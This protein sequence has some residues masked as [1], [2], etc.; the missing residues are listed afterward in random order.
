M[1]SEKRSNLS[2]NKKNDDYYVSFAV[3]TTQ[4][5]PLPVFAKPKSCNFSRLLSD[6]HLILLY[7]FSRRLRIRNAELII[8]NCEKDYIFIL[9][10]ILEI[11]LR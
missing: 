4:K 5:K 2:T 1:D 10:E 11:N 6:G 3:Y 7:L 9:V 8:F